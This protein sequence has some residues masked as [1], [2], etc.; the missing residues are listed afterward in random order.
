[1]TAPAGQPCGAVRRSRVACLSP[2]SCRAPAAATSAS[3]PGWAAWICPDGPD[4]G[5]RGS[6]SP[7]AT[8]VSG[9]GVIREC[10]PLAVGWGYGPQGTHTAGA[11]LQA[12]R[13]WSWRLV[14][15]SASYRGFLFDPAYC[16]TCHPRRCQ[17]CWISAA[18]SRPMSAF[19]ADAG[20][21][22]GQ[23]LARVR[24][25]D[26]PFL[27]VVKGVRRFHPVEMRLSATMNSERPTVMRCGVDPMAFIL[28]AAQGGL[29]RRA[30]FSSMCPAADTGR[31]R[32][33]RSRRARTSTRPTIRRWAGPSRRRSELPSAFIAG[34]QR[35][36]D[37][38]RLLS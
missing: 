1:M 22:S 37:R 36:A 29:S 20:R 7:V 18:S 34:R 13:S 24:R 3:M 27:L 30:R 5:R 31:P 4:P 23:S 33:T 19:I 21:V 28:A 2:Y 32:R 11:G 6:A 12:R 26:P 38:R 15:A 14:C 25:R 10:Q 8:S 35:D 16:I 17:T 9:K